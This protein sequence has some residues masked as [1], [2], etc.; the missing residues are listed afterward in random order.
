M[1]RP[2]KYASAAERQDAYRSRYAVREI[3]LVKETDETLKQ[4]AL[5]LDC[6]VTELVNSLIN[7]ALLN[8]NW[9]ALGLFGKRLPYSKNPL[10][11]SGE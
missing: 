7:F 1:G 2:A 9:A 5:H 11:D 3:R 10:D 4:L 8:R 6:P